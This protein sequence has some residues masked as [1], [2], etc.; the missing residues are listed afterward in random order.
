MSGGHSATMKTIL[1]FSLFLLLPTLVQAASVS[2][3]PLEPN[4][5]CQ[6]DGVATGQT[7]Y[8]VT[9]G[10]TFDGTIFNNISAFQ[11]INEIN[12]ALNND[13]ESGIGDGYPDDDKGVGAN[14][15][16]I[17]LAT[18]LFTNANNEGWPDEN[19]WFATEFEF[20]TVGKTEAEGG[21]ELYAQFEAVSA[22]E[23]AM[24]AMMFGGVALLAPASRKRRTQFVRQAMPDR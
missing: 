12:A 3:C 15:Y 13:D 23:P 22:P 4:L 21:Q 16:F 24:I 20:N 8:D 18:D 11:I 10:N 17:A 7:T 2:V 14:T 5:V 1:A 19:Q 6:I 9:F